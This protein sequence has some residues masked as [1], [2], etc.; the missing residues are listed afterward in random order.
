MLQ[1][2]A[3][4]PRE[5]DRLVSHYY[6]VDVHPSLLLLAIC[7]TESEAVDSGSLRLADEAAASGRLEVFADGEWITVCANSWS[8]LNTDVAC[9]ELGFPAALSWST[10]DQVRLRL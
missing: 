3:S 8:R 6:S 5:S 1:A 4:D 2:I 10:L 9:R 7:R